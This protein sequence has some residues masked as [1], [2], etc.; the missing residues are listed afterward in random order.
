MQKSKLR[1][2]QKMLL[3]LLIRKK[4]HYH[5]SC[6]VKSRGTFEWWEKFVNSEGFESDCVGNFSM[7]IKSFK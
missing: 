6:W 2:N 3:R 4:R 7:S 5:Q 1:E